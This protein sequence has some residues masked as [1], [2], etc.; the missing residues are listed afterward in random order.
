MY[1]LSVLGKEYRFPNHSLH[2]AGIVGHGDCL[3]SMPFV[4]V[5]ILM[6][7][8]TSD[9]YYHINCGGDTKM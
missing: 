5:F 1:L 2:G 3:P 6:S 8:I 7:V 4:S 9:L